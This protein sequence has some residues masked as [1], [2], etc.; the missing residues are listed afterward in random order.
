MKKKYF[1]IVIV[2]LLF[3]PSLNSKAL[4]NTNTND[5]KVSMH[6]SFTNWKELDPTVVKNYSLDTQNTY[7]SSASMKLWGT[8]RLV[9]NL[10]ENNMEYTL[11][12]NSMF[13]FAWK[14]QS[15]QYDYI[16]FILYTPTNSYY[17]VSYFGQT[18]FVNSSTSAIYEFS[19]EKPNTWYEHEVN[20]TA[21]FLQSYGFLPDKIVSVELINAYFGSNG[22]ITSNQVSYFDNFNFVPLSTLSSSNSN[23][24]V[25]K[26]S[27]NQTKSLWVQNSTVTGGNY[28]FSTLQTYWSNETLNLGGTEILYLNLTSNNM[29]Y[30]L[31]NN[32]LFKFAWNFASNQYDYIGFI[33]YTQNYTC[34]IVSYFGITIFS[35]TSYAVIDEF[36]NE[37][38][39]TWYSHEVNLTSLILQNFGTIH[40]QKI[41]GI[42]LINAYFGTYPQTGSEPSNQMSYFDDFAFITNATSISAEQS[43]N[44]L[45]ISMQ[46]IFNDWIDLNTSFKQNYALSSINTYNGSDS[47]NL[48]NT[49]RLLLNLTANN[50]EYSLSS[51]LNHTFFKF[52]WNFVTNQYDYI[53]FIFYTPNQTYYVISFFGHTIFHNSTYAGI[54]EFINEQPNTWYSHEVDLSAL[55]SQSFGFVP[56]KIT[57]IM[58]INAYFGTYP[59]TGSEP[60]NQVS[61]YG[62]FELY[63]ALSSIESVI[64]T[65]PVPFA[66]MILA[67]PVIYLMRKRK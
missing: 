27:I 47:M 8:N 66:F 17:I 36:N 52:S 32:S 37:Q 55:F 49:D 24:Q 44:Y 15:T 42:K 31:T 4:T 12:N 63:S 39:N 38:P 26:I 45:S 25:Q 35:N 1:T 23:T 22:L 33:L 3:L 41:V 10:T 6:D 43:G 51:G 11:T 19:N 2:F 67:F 28:S 13:K 54:Y 20:L 57:S 65:S 18:V 50:M 5:L 46:N 14:F 64:K 62:D 30:N 34:Y 60:S 48:N 40:H 29:E 53:G 56:Q 16:G 58:L 61:Y 9:L 21:L 7:W 59:Q